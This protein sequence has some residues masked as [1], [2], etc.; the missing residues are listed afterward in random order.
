MILHGTEICVRDYVSNPQTSS[1]MK[2]LLLQAAAYC[3]AISRR[4]TDLT[5]A[6]ELRD[7]AADIR[8][9]VNAVDAQAA[10]QPGEERSGLSFPRSRCP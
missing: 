10:G 3:E 4:C 5:A 7:L 6:G 8:R 9:R 2:D 1:A